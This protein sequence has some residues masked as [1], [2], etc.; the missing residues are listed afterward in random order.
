MLRPVERVKAKVWTSADYGKMKQLGLFDKGG[1]VVET[2]YDGWGVQLLLPHLLASFEHI[3][4]YGRETLPSYELSVGNKGMAQW[5]LR[6]ERCRVK[7]SVVV[8]GELLARSPGGYAPA[9]HIPT[10]LK[11]FRDTKRADD[12]LVF[13]AYAVGH[14]DYENVK[15]WLPSEHRRRLSVDLGLDIPHHWPDLAADPHPDKLNEAARAR[16]LEGFVI[17]H[18][19]YGW[20]KH[21]VERTADLVIMGYKPG[22]G[23]YC[24]IIG[25][26][27]CGAWNSDG[28]LVEVAS[29]SG[30]G[31]PERLLITQRSKELIGTV[32]EVEYQ[33]RSK[34][35]LRHPRFLRFRPDKPAAECTLATL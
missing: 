27:H 13:I 17:K 12:S 3:Q 16:G 14:W 23:K 6:F 10:R 28:K 11:R 20:F 1:T 24:G 7:D 33:E 26:V 34:K 30:M 9:A 5:L 21:K 32:I 22:N 2:K 31:D 18:P 8:M 19:R 4:M 35:R 25:S 15:A 29:V